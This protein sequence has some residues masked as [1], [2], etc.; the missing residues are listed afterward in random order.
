MSLILALDTVTNLCHC[1]LYH[2]GDCLARRCDDLGKGH[3][4]HITG[5]IEALLHQAGTDK[6]ALTRI[7]VVCGPGSFTG[8]RVGV[9]VARSLGLALGIAAIGV[10][11]FAAIEYG[12]RHISSKQ[13][14][15]FCAV[16]LPG[17]HDLVSFQ[18]FDATGA[19]L[20]PPRQEKPEEIAKQLPHSTLLS[21]ESCTQIVSILEQDPLTDIA[22]HL[23]TPQAE[24]DNVAA[25]AA[26]KPLPQPSPSPLY[27]RPPDAKP[28]QPLIRR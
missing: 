1:A 2:D 19:A 25:I 27:M 12:V 24:L 4:E 5:Q 22:V 18:L 17:I 9:A 15:Q 11:R 26:A 10:S 23:L 21:G 8:M 28:A 14:K 13:Q 3:G 20:A 7:A 6:N 16:I